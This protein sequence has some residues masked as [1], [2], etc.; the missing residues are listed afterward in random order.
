[1][2]VDSDRC[3]HK[4]ND[5]FCLFVCLFVFC[6][7][8]AEFTLCVLLYLCFKYACVC[9]CVSLLK[10]GVFLKKKGNMKRNFKETTKMSLL[11]LV[12]SQSRGWNKRKSVGVSP[13]IPCHPLLFQRKRLLEMLFL[14]IWWATTKVG[15]ESFLWASNHHKGSL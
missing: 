10:T 4:N 1:M 7:A 11:N 2:F 15:N 5:E 3:R 13:T 9:F 12:E 6:Y 8:S 14:R